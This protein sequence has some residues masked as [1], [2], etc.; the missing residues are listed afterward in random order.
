MGAEPSG[1]SGANRDGP[2]AAKVA[3]RTAAITLSS[4]SSCSDVSDPLWNGD[5][6]SWRSAERLMMSRLRVDLR[7]DDDDE[8]DPAVGDG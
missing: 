6:D 2:A 1:A 3:A 4:G 7:L 5:G 8:A